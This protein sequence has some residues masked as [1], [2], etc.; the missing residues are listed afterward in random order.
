M[1]IKDIAASSDF[2]SQC[3]FI[4]VYNKAKEE[5]SIPRGNQIINEDD[6]LFL[7]SAAEHIKEAADFLTAAKA[8]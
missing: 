2:S 1:S 8:N 7:I 4:A 3:T 6:E 5:F